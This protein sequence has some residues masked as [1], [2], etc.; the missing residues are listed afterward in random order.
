MQFYKH[1]ISLITLFVL[2]ATT[3][4]AQPMVSAGDSVSVSIITCS[5][6]TD[7]YTHFGHTALRVIN[8]TKGDDITF[9]YGCFDPSM[10]NFVIKFMIGET[11]Y[12]LGA[13]WT[14][15]FIERYREMG[16]EVVQQDLNLTQAESHRLFELLLENIRPENQQYRYNWLY[17]NCTERARDIIAK[18]IDGNIKYNKEPLNITTREMLHECTA[19]SL[20]LQLGIDMLLGT[21]IDQPI[22]RDVWTFIPAY[23]MAEAD[24]AEITP[25]EGENAELTSQSVRP[26]VSSRHVL[27]DKTAPEEELTF[28]TP[29]GAFSLLCVLSSLISLSDWRRKRLSTWFDVTLHIAQGAAGCIIAFLFFFSSHPAVGSNWHVVVFNPIALFYSAWMICSKKYIREL[30]IAETVI[31]VLFFIFML[32]GIQSFNYC[33]YFII[34]ALTIRSAT[35]TCRALHNTKK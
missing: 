9:N 16:T 8:H 29:I 4:S 15:Y 20:W 32:T 3:L 23:Y 12:V 34:F 6:G 31:L 28:P 24:E 14:S 18:A 7:A 19:R 35:R 17:D 27:L 1:Y 33:I 22:D 26:L 2:M 10:D 25:A 5:P 13:E 21:E 30:A 11:D